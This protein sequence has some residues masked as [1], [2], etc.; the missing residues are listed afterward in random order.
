[1]G[2]YKKAEKLLFSA[3]T[4]EEQAPKAYNTLGLISFKR[5]EFGSAVS[6]FRQSILLDD[7]DTEVLVNLANVHAMQMEYKDAE[8]VFL[9]AEAL[10]PS[11]KFIKYW[12]GSTLYLAKEYNKAGVKLTE[13]IKLDPEFAQ[14][15]LQRAFVYKKLGNREEYLKDYGKAITLNPKLKIN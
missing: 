9:K 7:K 1:M 12:L 13:A 15:Y 2:Q 4:E 6:H 11:D 3:V 5:K 10:K 8:A 14:G